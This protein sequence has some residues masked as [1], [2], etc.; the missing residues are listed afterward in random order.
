MSYSTGRPNENP[1]MTIRGCH[2]ENVKQHPTY[3]YLTL[4]AFSSTVTTT[5]WMNLFNSYAVEIAGLDGDLVS[6]IQSSG[7]SP[8]SSPFLSSISSSWSESITWLLYRSYSLVS[9]IATQKIPSQENTD[10][11]HCTE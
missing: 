7:K 10:H 4:L 5:C 1:G 2:T 8:D 3:Q 9:L 11:R 6:I